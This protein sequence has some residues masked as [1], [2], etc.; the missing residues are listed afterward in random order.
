MTNGMGA[1]TVIWCHMSHQCMAWCA[2]L[3]VTAC[4]V[5]IGYHI[6]YSCDH[7]GMVHSPSNDSYQV[8]T[9]KLT[10]DNGDTATMKITG[11]Q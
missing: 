4:T 7:Y 3:M 1:M 5:T 8:T 11:W 2:A 10:P 6:G 9:P